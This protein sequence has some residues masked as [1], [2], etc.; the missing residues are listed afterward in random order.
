MA[1]SKSRSVK[2]G[3]FVFAGFVLATIAVFLIGDNRRQWD[4]KVTFHAKFSNVAGLRVGASVRMGGLDV[5]SVS[6]VSY[7]RPED[8]LIGVTFDVA[9]KEA[10]RVLVG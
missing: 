3:L 5:G 9:K 10:P 1:N 7:E 8:P 2:I 4:R 6:S